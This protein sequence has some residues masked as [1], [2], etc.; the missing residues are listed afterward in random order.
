LLEGDEQT[1]QLQEEKPEGWRNV[2]APVSLSNDARAGYLEPALNLM[3]DLQS[4][5]AGL[6]IEVSGPNGLIIAS[7]ATTSEFWRELKSPE[8]H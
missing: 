4:A 8:G 3:R 7:D 1:D 2:G 6:R 5:T